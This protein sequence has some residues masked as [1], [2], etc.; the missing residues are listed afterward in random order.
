MFRGKRTKKRRVKDIAIY[1]RNP[2]F[3][4]DLV[5][6]INQVEWA[7]TSKIADQLHA[8]D[9][10]LV[11]FT[12]VIG[13]RVGESLSL[14]R[15]WFHVEPDRISIA[16][17]QPE[18]HGLLRSGLWLP[19]TGPLA[20]LTEIFYKWLVQVPNEPEAYIFPT[21]KPFGQINWNIP[22]EP[23]R[24]HWIIQ[25]TIKKFPHWFR[26]VCETYYAKVVFR[27]DGFK[28]KEF[29]GIRRFENI[30]CYVGEPWRQDLETFSQE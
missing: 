25:S 15:K 2:D 12:C 30:V 29:M 22:L 19:R 26:A 11:A 20:P 10:A 17:I 24:M 18:K 23:A 14:Q 28:L 27:N 1:P 6:E 9:K 13:T 16:D 5:A 4:R 21:A 8:R 7:Y 3:I